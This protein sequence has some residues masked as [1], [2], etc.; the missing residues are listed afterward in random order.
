MGGAFGHDEKKECSVLMD[1]ADGVSTPEVAVVIITILA[2]S[3]LIAKF[4]DFLK[5]ASANK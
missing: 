5:V 4:L 1:F 3:W 2:G